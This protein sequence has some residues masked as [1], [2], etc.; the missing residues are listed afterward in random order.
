MAPDLF[1]S[2]TTSTSGN[3]GWVYVRDQSFEVR[4]FNRNRY[5]TYKYNGTASPELFW[6][7][8]DKYDT[9]YTETSIYLNRDAEIRIKKLLKKMADALCKQGWIDHKPYYSEPLPVLAGLRG[10]RL[11]GRGWGNRK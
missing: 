3:W 6:S 1:N 7:H 4:R 8:H 2:T 9:S 10:V 5:E 11:D